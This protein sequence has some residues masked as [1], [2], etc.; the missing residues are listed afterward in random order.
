M[1]KAVDFLKEKSRS[2]KINKSMENAYKKSI[3]VFEESIS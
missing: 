1:Q 3:K 2:P